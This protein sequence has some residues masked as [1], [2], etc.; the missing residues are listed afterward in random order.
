MAS[1]QGQSFIVIDDDDDEYPTI[2]SD[3]S[4]N[5][6]HLHERKLLSV[7]YFNRCLFPAT[8]LW[9]LPLFYGAFRVFGLLNDEGLPLTPLQVLGKGHCLSRYIY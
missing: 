8:S 5:T 9:P 3:G 7:G 1:L 6:D 2:G 4:K